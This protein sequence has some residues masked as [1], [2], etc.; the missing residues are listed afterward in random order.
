[1]TRHQ[2]NM[3]MEMRRGFTLVELMIV[4]AVIIIVGATSVA[5]G[6]TYLSR[7]QAES[8]AFQLVQDLRD[9]QSTAVFTRRYV[10]VSFFP[11]ANYYTFEKSASGSEVRRDLT[12]AAGFAEYVTGSAAPGVSVSLSS[13]YQSPP[14]S[15]VDLYFT[16]SGTPSTSGSSLASLDGTEGRISISARSGTIIDV[17]I[18]TVLGRIRMEWR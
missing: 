12:S 3:M 1:M 15:R 9:A 17:Y 7:R 14:S 2:R 6:G 18:S 8:A 5:Y 16:P 13:A 11:S 10:R 4:I